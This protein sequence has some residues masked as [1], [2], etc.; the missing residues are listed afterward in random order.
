MNG[1]YVCVYNAKG[2]LDAEI[3]KSYLKSQGYL[4][5]I[6]QESAGLTLG[7]TIG[8]LG[9]AKTLVKKEDEESV[10]EL[11]ESVFQDDG[12]NFVT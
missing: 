11:L 12:D 4:A 7:L 5:I 8:R 2:Q 1:N 10:R 9:T 6:S 3:I